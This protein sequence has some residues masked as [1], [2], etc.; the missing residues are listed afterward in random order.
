[1]SL[2]LAFPRQVFRLNFQGEFLLY[3]LNRTM[4]LLFDRHKILYGPYNMERS[5]DMQMLQNS[6]SA[7]NIPCLI[8]SWFLAQSFETRNK[9]KSQ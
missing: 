1:M 4:R 2:S 7:E 9:R 8:Y 5:I 6:A 3:A